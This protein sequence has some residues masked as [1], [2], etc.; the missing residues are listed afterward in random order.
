[1]NAIAEILTSKV[2]RLRGHMAACEEHRA[3]QR[4]G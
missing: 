3:A 4:D 1:M 2:R